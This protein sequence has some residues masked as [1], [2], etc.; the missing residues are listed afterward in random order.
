MSQSVKIAGALF[1]N[2]PSISVPD[3]N[4]VYHSFV[5]TSDADA[6]ASDIL[7]PK[8]A[9]VNGVKVVGTGSGGGGGLEYEAG[10]FTVS[11]NT[12]RPTITF[13][14]AHT[15]TPMFVMVADATGT[16]DSTTQTYHS[17]ALY[18]TSKIGATLYASSSSTSIGEERY[19]YRATNASQFSTGTISLANSSSLSGRLTSTYFTPG[20]GSTRKY[21]TGR[22][23]K[24]IAVWAP[25]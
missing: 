7:A 16:Y 8:T 13:L 20:T 12:T 17:D 23:Y 9:Y 5:D 25:T 14:N 22:T 19:T 6:T 3:A 24:W 10:T 2:V 15:T 1:Q 21:I 18:D 11:T 4:D